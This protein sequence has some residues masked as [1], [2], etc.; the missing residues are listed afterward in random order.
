MYESL[1]KRNWHL[2]KLVPE[3]HLHCVH[4][5]STKDAA[6]LIYSINEFIFQISNKERIIL[7][8]DINNKNFKQE[9]VLTK[10]EKKLHRML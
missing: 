7:T 2:V 10:L 3:L 6:S 4:Q 9:I 5:S 1:F 8:Q